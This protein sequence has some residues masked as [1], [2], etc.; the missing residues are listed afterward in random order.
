[1]YILVM[2][3]PLGCYPQCRIKGIN[4][5]NDHWLRLYLTLITLASAHGYIPEYHPANFLSLQAPVQR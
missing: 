4:Y 1:M 5:A 3:Y 2:N